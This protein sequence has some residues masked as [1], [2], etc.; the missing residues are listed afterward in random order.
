MY[1]GHVGLALGAKGWRPALPLAALVIAAQGPDWID[2]G[3]TAFRITGDR[4]E[5][6][7]HSLPAV[8]IASLFV[9]GI[10]LFIWRSRQ[11]LVL[12]AVY[13]LHLPADYFTGLKPLGPGLPSIGLQ[14]YNYPA[15]DFVLEAIVIVAGW[16]LWKRSLPND[17][18]DRPAAWLLLAGLLAVQAAGD[19]AFA[20]RAAH[21]TII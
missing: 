8:L 3:L 10:S 2:T 20:I 16:Q 15:V 5:M 21:I 6:F 1:V 13:L 14:L 17:R 11:A 4:A 7:S 19:V 9:A 12:P 18:R